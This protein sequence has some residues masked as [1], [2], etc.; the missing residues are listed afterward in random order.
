MLTRAGTTIVKCALLISK[1]EQRRRLE[2]RLKDPTKRW[3][4]QIGDLDD[5]ALWKEYQSAFSEAIERTSTNDAPWYV[6]PADHKWYRNWAISRLLIETL[7]E[8]NPQYPEPPDLSG[9]KIYLTHMEE[10]T[11][12]IPREPPPFSTGVARAP[13]CFFHMGVVPDARGDPDRIRTD[14]LHLD[15]VAC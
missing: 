11:R 10:P 7:D 8:M 9:V 12:G 15:R 2:E 4:F 14:D 5:R 6:I 13:P 3:K 1:D